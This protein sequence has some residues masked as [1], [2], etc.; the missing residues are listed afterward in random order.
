MTEGLLLDPPA[1]D[2]DHAIGDAD[3]VKGIGHARGVREVRTQPGPV[4]VGEIEGDHLDAVAP[5]SRPSGA[6][7]TQL[8]GAF[9]F[10]EVDDDAPVQIDQ[11][12]GVDG[13]VLGRGRE[14]GVLVDPEGAHG[15]H[16]GPVL[17]EGPAV[18]FDRSPGGVPAHAVLERHRGD[19]A[20]EVPDLAGDFGSGAHRE[21]LARRDAG[22]LLGPGLLDRRGRCGGET[23]SFGGQPEVRDC[24]HLEIADP[25]GWDSTTAA[26]REGVV[27][28]WSH[29]R[30]GPRPSSCNS[31]QQA[32]GDPFRATRNDKRGPT[33]NNT[34]SVRITFEQVV[35]TNSQFTT[36]SS[37]GFPS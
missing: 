9:T 31:V 35:S 28:A 30:C 6:Q 24:G 21:H 18:V 33:T 14:I 13:R 15:P 5:G 11:A 25:T 7:T 34:T 17:D 1:D 26:L 20:T 12:G 2:V 23:P 27:G 16:P 36:L 37:K 10:E 29:F 19:G 8:D 32:S 4:G 22:E 3:H